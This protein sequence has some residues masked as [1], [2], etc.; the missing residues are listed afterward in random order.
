MF[1]IV[2]TI[3]ARLLFAYRGVVYGEGFTVLGLPYVRAYGKLIIG[4]SVTINSGLKA[5]AVFGVGCNVLISKK[6]AELIIGDNVGMSNVTIYSE[7]SITVGDNTLL[8]AGVKIW[9]TDFHSLD[10]K[11][12]M[13]PGDRGVS[14]AIS[15]GK[16]CFIGAGS[17]IL[18]GV[19]IGDNAV[20]GAGSV[21]AKD[22]PDNEVW[23]GN[24][25]RF[26]KKICP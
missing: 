25:C 17:M 2:S 7:T 1:K 21:V 9:D 5:N 23:A 12:R 18:K 14:A 16:N 15:I 22:V 19:S 6:D 20:I 11:I 3:L 24:P 4:N 10:A 26:I 8:G 13:T